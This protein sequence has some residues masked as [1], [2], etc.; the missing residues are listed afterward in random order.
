MRGYSVLLAALAMTML[1][2]AALAGANDYRFEVVGKPAKVIR[3]RL[4]H[5][6]DGA[7]VAGAIL[8]QP[9]LEMGEHGAM[10]A[11]VKL[12]PATE[13]GTYTLEAKP[14]MSG[15]WVLSFGAKVP[16]EAAT[17]RAQ[18]TLNLDE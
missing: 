4:L 1:A 6:P 7:P 3:L 16:G 12:L 8:I 17:L 13:P 18:I 5:L 15:Q 10:S 14:S 2:G 11:P 9:K